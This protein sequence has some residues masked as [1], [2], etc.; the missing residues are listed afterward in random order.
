MSGA[1][2]KNTAG[3]V[4]FYESCE[5]AETDMRVDHLGLVLISPMFHNLRHCIRQGPSPRSGS[6]NVL[7]QSPVQYPYKHLK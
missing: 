1:W 4:K 2:G 7:L 5:V 3:S 6:C